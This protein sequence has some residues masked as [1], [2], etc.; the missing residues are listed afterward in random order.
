MEATK[1]VQ[2]KRNMEE[3][4]DHILSDADLEEYK[5]IGLLIK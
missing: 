3:D 5:K 2:Q 4:L 1:K